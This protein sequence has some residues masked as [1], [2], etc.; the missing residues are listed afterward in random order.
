MSDAVNSPSHYSEGRSLE[1]IDVIEDWGLGFHLGNAV[2]YIA[3]AGRKDDILQDLRKAQW[4]LNREIENLELEQ[5]EVEGD[6]PCDYNELLACHAAEPS[7]SYYYWD[8]TLGPIEPS[9]TIRSN[10]ISFRG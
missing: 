1:T 3:R 4:Y 10:V 5:A 2:K 7:E 9:D 6:L 8:P